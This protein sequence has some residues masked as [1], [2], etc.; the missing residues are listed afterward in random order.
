MSTNRYLPVGDECN[1]IVNYLLGSGDKDLI[2]SDHENS[3]FTILRYKGDLFTLN[4]LDGQLVKLVLQDGNNI[5][6]LFEL[7][8]MISSMVGEPTIYYEVE[9]ADSKSNYLQS[10]LEWV[11]DKEAELDYISAVTNN[12]SK[13]N[14]KYTN[15][16]LFNDTHIK[17]YDSYTKVLVKN[18]E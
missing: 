1:K 13:E 15:I 8:T 7:G 17:E 5:S 16:K 11:F 9:S 3:P 2:V 10:V 18:A 6:A 12:E 4:S 14:I